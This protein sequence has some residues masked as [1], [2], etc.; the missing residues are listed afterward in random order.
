[1]R[2]IPLQAFNKSTDPDPTKPA[3][4]PTGNPKEMDTPNAKLSLLW[5]GTSDN[6]GPKKYLNLSLEDDSF[7]GVLIDCSDSIIFATDAKGRVCDM[8]MNGVYHLRAASDGIEDMAQDCLEC[9]DRHYTRYVDRACRA[10]IRESFNAVM[11]GE[12]RRLKLVTLVTGDFDFERGSAGHDLS[13]TLQMYPRYNKHG[14]V[15]GVVFEA[16]D[17]SAET[18]LAKIYELIL[19]G[20]G[21][22]VKYQQP[23]EYDE[24]VGAQALESMNNGD[25]RV[26]REK[27]AP[28]LAIATHRLGETNPIEHCTDAAMRVLE[29]GSIHDV[30]GRDFSEFLADDDQLETFMQL[31][32]DVMLKRASDTKDFS[33]KLG[34]KFQARRLTLIPWFDEN[35]KIKGLI[36]S[37]AMLGGEE[38][39]FV[40]GQDGFVVDCTSMAAR[41]IG[42]P[43]EDIDGV[44]LVRFLDED[45]LLSAGDRIMDIFD[46]DLDPEE[47][48]ACTRVVMKKESGRMF[49]VTWDL[50]RFYTPTN[51]MRAMVI[52]HREFN[53]GVRG[54]NN[55]KRVVEEEEHIDLRH[56]EP[57]QRQ[58][59]PEAKEEDPELTAAEK[60]QRETE[61][62]RFHFC[63]MQK[64]NEMDGEC[65]FEDFK[66][67]LRQ[68]PVPED[69]PW[70]LHKTNCFLK[71][72]MQLKYQEICDTKKFNNETFDFETWMQWWKGRTSPCPQRTMWDG[73]EKMVHLPIPGR[74]KATD[75]DKL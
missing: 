56:V 66:T 59:K 49:Q 17:I 23:L 1:M 8:N 18:L 22:T 73:G 61:P 68:F 58:A 71:K 20:D 47:N 26:I 46:E 50:Q 43:K 2:A 9:I 69:R 12:S 40:M 33:V 16:K 52:M 14:K 55:S 11:R 3:Y 72:P 38:A 53:L 24:S 6:D 5:S 44:P 25:D 30:V 65:S 37:L 32:G 4:V 7:C 70:G 54:R 13:A 31:R 63:L 60:A 29:A 36:V 62:V 41:M 34:N 45:S 75:M 21:N 51:E 15:A 67:Y 42:Y 64:E 28:I 10:E 27:H 19:Y 35:A 39:G 57:S 74:Q 48:A